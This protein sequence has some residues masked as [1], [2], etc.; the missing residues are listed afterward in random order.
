M[1]PILSLNDNVKLCLVCLGPEVHV[2]QQ[3][4]QE[5]IEYNDLF[6][7]STIGKLPVVY[8]MCLDN[9]VHPTICAP[10]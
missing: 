1:K 2:I 9:S 5:L 6:D 8:H 7:C 3:I 4:A 10:R